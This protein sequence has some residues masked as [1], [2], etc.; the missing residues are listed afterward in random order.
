MADVVR[1]ELVTWLN[2]ALDDDE[3]IAKAAGERSP[4]WHANEEGYGAGAVEHDGKHYAPIVYDEGY[5]SEDEA[6]HIARHDPARVLAEVAAKRRILALHSE[7]HLCPD[8]DGILGGGMYS[9]YVT[10]D[11]CPTV[12]VLA[13]PYAG[14]E[15]WNPT[16]RP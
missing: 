10:P 2:A 4:N 12:R 15:G 13:L 5:P 14:R 11:E 7:P 16:W 1:D 8:V 3:R 9:A 6:E